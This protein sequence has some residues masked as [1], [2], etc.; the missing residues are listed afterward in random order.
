MS[1]K[2]EKEVV[3]GFRLKPSLKENVDKLIKDSGKKD[4]EWLEDIIIKI[5]SDEL[6]L[7]KSG[8]S[9]ELRKNFSSD[10]SSL[11]D[12]TNLITT[13]F[14]NQMNRIAVEKNN[15]SDHLQKT[16]EEY[17]RKLNIQKAQLRELE[18]TI[19]SKD[20]VLEENQNTILQ[21]H[22]KVDGFDKLEAQLR[23]DIERLESDKEKSEN[24]LQRIR[25][26]RLS[27][28]EQLQDSM[29]ELKL[30]HK[31]ER[32]RLNQQIVDYINKLKEI[33]PISKENED[34][35]VQVKEL[36]ELLK[37]NNQQYELDITRTQE[38]AEIEKEKALLVRER[39]LRESLHS[40]NRNDQKELYE[41]IEKL[42]GD[43]QSLKIENSSL[44][45]KINNN[46]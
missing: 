1:E 8:I 14:I 35:K 33:E 24:D 22:T 32:D 37:M 15:W 30:T 6:V 12:A 7:D 16:I 38:Q 2:V 44:L 40:E 4:G 36:Q 5:L 18:S 42:Q 23:K 3:K 17:E 43:I 26:E 31:Y 19:I 41:K 13:I 39:E 11:K 10:I 34:L 27:E 20:D 25:E 29:D 28:K 45:S 21:L 46:K 9:H